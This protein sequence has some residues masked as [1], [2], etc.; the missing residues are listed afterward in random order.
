LIRPGIQLKPIEG[1]ATLANRDL[2]KVWTDFGIE[3]VAIHAEIRAGASCPDP[4]RFNSWAFCLRAG[5]RVRV[6]LAAHVFSTRAHSAFSPGVGS[7]A[8]HQ[9]DAF[10]WPAED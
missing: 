9:L 2:S 1:D 10:S 3:T 6:Q 8:G 4:P 7:M 5:W